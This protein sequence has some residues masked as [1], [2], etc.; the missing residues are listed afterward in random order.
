MKKLLRNS[1]RFE[2]HASPRMV[3]HLFKPE[4]KYV[5]LTIEKYIPCLKKI[6]VAVKGASP[7]LRKMSEEDGQLIA[8]YFGVCKEDVWRPSLVAFPRFQLS[9]SV[10]HK[11]PHS[12]RT[13]DM[14]TDAMQQIQD[15]SFF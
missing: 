14:L 15:T 5:K 13:T 6:K 11:V 7:M 9:P 8:R 12:F 2:Y 4:V 3:P 1:E 10:V